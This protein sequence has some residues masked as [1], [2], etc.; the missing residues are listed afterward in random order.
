MRD[1][2]YKQYEESFVPTFDRTLE[3]LTVTSV[4][5][6]WS[7]N[8]FTYTWCRATLQRAMTDLG[9][10][11]TVGPNHYDEAHEKTTIML[12][13]ENFIKKMREYRAAGCTIYYT[14]ETW[15]NKN[16]TPSRAWTDRSLCARLKVPSGKG[17]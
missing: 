10:K 5:A 4:V 1:A 17:A 13:L 16:V 7:G 6:G 2:V 8:P 9:V 12:Q 3:H 14:D 15:A 11:F